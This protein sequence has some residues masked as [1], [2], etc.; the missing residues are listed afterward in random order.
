MKE[1][2]L[3]GM[4]SARVSKNKKRIMKRK[5]GGGKNG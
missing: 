5:I 4:L 2:V 1:E 3:G